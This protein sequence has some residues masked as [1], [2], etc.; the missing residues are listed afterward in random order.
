MLRNDESSKGR[1]NLK[2]E[3]KTG[4]LRD[5]TPRK[6]VMASSLDSHLLPTSNMRGQALSQIRLLLSCPRTLIGH[7]Y[8]FLDSRLQSAGMTGREIAS[9][10]ED[11]EAISST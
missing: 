10:R 9:H 5:K 2:Q 1:S 4:L 11:I 6:D 8:F 3:K 7:P